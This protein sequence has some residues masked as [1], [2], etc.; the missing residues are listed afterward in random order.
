LGVVASDLNQDGHIDFYVANDAGAN[1][2]YLGTGDGRF[3]EMGEAAGVALNELGTPEGSMGVDAED[4]D[5]DGRMEVWTTNF[6]LEDNSLYRNLGHGQFQHATAAFGLAGCGRPLVG[7]GTGFCDFDSDGWP[8]L[9]V[10]NGHV[11][12]RHGVQPF[13]QPAAVYRNDGG[14]RFVDVTESAG[15]WF[16]VPHAARG[17]AVGD[18][19]GDGAPDLAVSSLDE[20]VVILRNRTL[21][22]NWVR[23]KLVGVQ[24][25]RDPVGARVRVPVFGRVCHKSIRSGAGFLS[26]SDPRILFALTVDET[27]IDVSVV[28]PTGRQEVFAG[29]RTATDHVIIEGRGMPPSAPTLD[30]S[31]GT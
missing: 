12:Y 8:D 26:Q 28:W 2:L 23:L 10:L 5:G 1:D 25:P 17:G 19:D 3:S 22:Q 20:P 4:V 16:Q 9:Y 21:P 15:T 30:S 11:W 27:T 6:E 24:S 13:R 31:T 29:L 18:L 7:F 14:R